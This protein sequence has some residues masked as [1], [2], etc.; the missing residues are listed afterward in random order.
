VTSSDEFVAAI[1]SRFDAAQLAPGWV[2]DIE[3]RAAVFLEANPGRPGASYLRRAV[4]FAELTAKAVRAGDA[5]QAVTAAVGALQAA[6][7]AEMI[8]AKAHWYDLRVAPK[9][10]VGEKFTAGRKRGS[11]SAVRL[12]VRRILKKNPGARTAEVWAAV[13]AKPPKG[14]EVHDTSNPALRHITTKNAP[15]TGFRQFANIVSE[16]RIQGLASP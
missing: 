3:V 5:E 9:V 16:E 1:A 13:K 12:A 11:V 2:H 8:E 4:R 10:G 15:P 14:V 7:Q 6:W